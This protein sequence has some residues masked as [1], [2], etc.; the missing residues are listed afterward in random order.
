M[1][2][3]DLTQTAHTG[4]LTGVQRLCRSLHRALAASGTARPVC[5]D[6]WQRAWRALDS[7]ELAALGAKKVTAQ[8]KVA[9]PLR[10]RARGLLRRA[11]TRSAPPLV[12]DALLV[13]EIFSAA[14]ARALPA[15]LSHVTGPRAAVFYDT[16]PLQLPELTPARTVARFPSY[17]RELLM[18]DGVA[19]ISEDSR[20]ALLDWWR[21][22]GVTAHPPVVAIPLGVDLPSAPLARADSDPALSA[23]VVLCVGSLEGRKNHLALLNACESLWARGLRF[24]LRLIGLAHPQTGRAALVRVRALQA[25][26]RPLRYDGAADD[27]TLAAAYAECAFTVYPSLREGFGLPVIESLARGKPCVCS[28]RGALGESTRGGGCIA[29]DDVG[30]ASLALALEPLLVRPAALTKLAAE[31]RARR[32]KSWEHYAREITDWMSGLPRRVG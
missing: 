21:W 20:D 22:C 17:L 11:F 12:G 6:P 25:A 5:H 19:A 32:F 7:A 28:A 13:P 4:A 9:W 15:L 8:R 16:I 31:A 29:L 14:T 23:P 26:G 30:A 24:E 27:A 18:F 1:I 2:F 3:L 10:V